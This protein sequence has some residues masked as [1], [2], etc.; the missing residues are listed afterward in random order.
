MGKMFTAARTAQSTFHAS[1]MTSS[2]CPLQ[3]E[4]H[5]VNDHLCLFS[6]KLHQCLSSSRVAW[7]NTQVP[8]QQ[9]SSSAHQTVIAFDQEAHKGALA[10]KGAGRR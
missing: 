7:F 9:S 10:M 8:T 4:F 6:V 5:S 1:E 3:Y 2:A